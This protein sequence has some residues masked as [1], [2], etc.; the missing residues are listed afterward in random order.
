M[1]VIQTERSLQ[2]VFS[3]LSRPPKTSDETCRLTIPDTLLYLHGSLRVWYHTDHDTGEVMKRDRREWSVQAIIDSFCHG[4]PENS[5]LPVATYLHY[6]S[7]S[8]GTGIVGSAMGGRRGSLQGSQV[9][10]NSNTSTALSSS[11]PSHEKKPRDSRVIA[12]EYCRSFSEDAEPL[13]IDYFDRDTLAAFLAT[14]D[15]KHNVVVQ[16]FVRGTSQNFTTLQMV[17]SP[18]RVVT[19]QRQNIYKMG[20]DHVPLYDRCNTHENTA[21]LSR[22]VCTT[23]KMSA[24][25]ELECKKIVDHIAAVESRHVV[26][27]VAFF[28]FNAQSVP[29]LLYASEMQITEQPTS[30]EELSRELTFQT[31]RKLCFISPPVI[32]SDVILRQGGVLRAPGGSALSRAVNVVN[33]AATTLIASAVVPKSGAS[34]DDQLDLLDQTFVSAQVTRPNRGNLSASTRLELAKAYAAIPHQS[35]Q[36]LQSELI[37]R[38]DGDRGSKFGKKYVPGPYSADLVQG[39]SGAAAG[40]RGSRPSSALGRGASPALSLKC[41]DADTLELS[42]SSR[43]GSMENET[44]ASSLLPDR[45]SSAMSFLHGKV[46]DFCRGGGGGVF[47][48]PAGPRDFRGSAGKDA[49]SEGGGAGSPRSRQGSMFGQISLEQ[50]LDELG[51]SMSLGRRRS[52]L[53]AEGASMLRRGSSSAGIHAMTV[54]DWSKI[55]QQAI[56]Y[57]KAKAAARGFTLLKQ[58]GKI[59][60][61]PDL[62]NP[63]SMDVAESQT[64]PHGGIQDR[65]HHSPYDEQKHSNSEGSAVDESGEDV[66]SDVEQTDVY[67]NTIRRNVDDD[68]LNRRRVG[69]PVNAITLRN[70]VSMHCLWEFFSHKI[71]HWYLLPTLRAHYNALDFLEDFLSV[72]ESSFY[73]ASASR[74]GGGGGGVTLQISLLLELL[75]T[76]RDERNGK[77][78][79]AITEG[80]MVESI[81]ASSADA[82]DLLSLSATTCRQQNTT[83]AGTGE[84]LYD[85]SFVGTRSAP[86]VSLCFLEA[87]LRAALPGTKLPSSA[88]PSVGAHASHGVGRPDEGSSA[89]VEPKITRSSF[90]GSGAAGLRRR[91]STATFGDIPTTPLKA[92]NSSGAGSVF[93][94]SSLASASCLGTLS[95]ISPEEAAIMAPYSVSSLAGIEPSQQIFLPAPS[96]LKSLIVPPTSSSSAASASPSTHRS[97]QRAILAPP[98]LQPVLLPSVHSLDPESLDRYPERVEEGRPAVAAIDERIIEIQN[99]D[100]D[101]LRK[102]IG[103]LRSTMNGIE[104]SAAFLKLEVFS[105]LYNSLRESYAAQTNRLCASGRKFRGSIPTAAS[106]QLQ[107]PLCLLQRPGG[108][109]SASRSHLAKSTLL[110]SSFTFVMDVVKSELHAAMREGEQLVEW[111]PS[112]VFR[113]LP[114]CVDALSLH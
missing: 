64:T 34:L 7:S 113:P 81:I 89:P 70:G 47:L 84:G 102:I 56:R 28:A 54:L 4:L 71:Y 93:N 105:Y 32:N 104:S 39:S 31:K 69:V 45:P 78:T 21:H 73:E 17:W 8:S 26:R 91:Q 107:L 94:A 23:A 79:A 92:T 19:M 33:S 24:R 86:I 76:A 77:K 111:P 90:S 44:A 15:N 40:R 48:R 9:G 109:G 68:E 96:F 29:T 51:A 58:N 88:A 74:V 66:F 99:V 87:L 72:L 10:G 67:F 59:K 2:F 52:S 30:M 14:R 42:S 103:G 108:G 85:A 38:R 36:R 5:R 60:P 61:L 110:E 13:C 22:E 80:E 1:V 82:A 95:A 65:E 25:I 16:K 62:R 55:V 112:M 83:S 41:D 53:N 50:Q 37:L 12:E 20:D 3:I 46:M 27:M 100:R 75:P 98:P 101:R 6:S 35:A 63:E 57:R 114:L 49:R 11:G 106:K 97:T 43:R 18:H